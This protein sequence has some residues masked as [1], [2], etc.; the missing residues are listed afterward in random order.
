MKPSLKW[1]GHSE[2]ITTASTNFAV[3]N[4]W[5]QN[6]ILKQGI[7]FQEL[8]SVGPGVL[9]A[10]ALRAGL[11]NRDLSVRIKNTVWN[12]TKRLTNIYSNSAPDSGL[13]KGLHIF[14]DLWIPAEKHNPSQLKEHIL[15]FVLMF[16]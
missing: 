15:T 6:S 9:S 12:K 16:F 5:L 8:S 14:Q 3:K 13:E 4:S 7:L 2:D 10:H 1:V 11:L